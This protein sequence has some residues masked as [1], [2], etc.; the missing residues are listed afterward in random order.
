MIYMNYI[1]CEK[2]LIKHYGKDNAVKLIREYCNSLD[3][4]AKALGKED[5]EF[6]CLYF[7]SDTFVVKDSNTNRQLSKGHYELWELANRIFVKMN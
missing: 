5:I 7:M 3:D 6:F 4:L 1:Y 2:Y